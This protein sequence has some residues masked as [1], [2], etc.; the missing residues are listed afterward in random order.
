MSWCSPLC[1]YLV[2]DSLCFLDLYVHFCDSVPVLVICLVFVFVFVFLDSVVD[3]CEF[4]V[5]LLFIVFNL[6][7]FLR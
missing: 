1:V 5:I 4:V 6:L 2:W 3:S 7:Q